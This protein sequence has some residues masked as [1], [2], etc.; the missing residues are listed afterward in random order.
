MTKQREC[1]LH[2]ILIACS[3]CETCETTSG[4]G[5]LVDI[6]TGTPLNASDVVKVRA[7]DPRHGHLLNYR[8]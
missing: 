7:E 1:I 6:C 5:R 4:S 8:F 2:I 3:K